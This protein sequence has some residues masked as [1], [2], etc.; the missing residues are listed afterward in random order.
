[1]KDEDRE[2]ERERE[3]KGMAVMDGMEASGTSR[4]GGGRRWKQLGESRRDLGT[5]ARLREQSA[6]ASGKEGWGE[7]PLDRLRCRQ[8]GANETTVWGGVEEFTRVC[9]H[10]ADYL[11]PKLVLVL[12]SGT[13][14]AD[15][16][17]W[18]AAQ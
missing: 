18:L 4:L 14:Q 15:R 9:C 3:R 12:R 5:W 6:A 10:S 16:Y 11:A 8:D 2:G 17:Y 13:W 7:G 1:M